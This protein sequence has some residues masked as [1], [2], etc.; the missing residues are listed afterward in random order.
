MKDSA[1]RHRK[2]IS[3]GVSILVVLFCEG[4]FAFTSSRM[5]V[6][7]NH[8]HGWSSVLVSLQFIRQAL[9]MTRLLDIAASLHQACCSLFVERYFVFV[10][11]V[12][13]GHSA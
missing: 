10:V 1:L 4:L 6:L 13:Q 3:A 2:H 12:S 9:C 7:G 8:Q 11:A 5:D